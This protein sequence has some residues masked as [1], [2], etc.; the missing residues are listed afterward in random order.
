MLHPPL[1]LILS[2]NQQNYNGTTA[3]GRDWVK[4]DK[5]R[6]GKAKQGKAGQGRAGQDRAGQDRTGLGVG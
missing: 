1:K 5:A 3:A 4:H 2:V 6:Q